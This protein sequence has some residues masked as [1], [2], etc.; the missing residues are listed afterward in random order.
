MLIEQ[1]K[2]IRDRYEHNLPISIEEMTELFSIVESYITPV[3]VPVVV[4]KPKR[5]PKAS[6]EA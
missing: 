3:D 4:E 5:V 1:L 6:V 2:D